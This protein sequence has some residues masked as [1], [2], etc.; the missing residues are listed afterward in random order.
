MRRG[1]R[2]LV[3]LFVA[4]VAALAVS[5][6]A[7]PMSGCGSRVVS[8][9]RDGRFDHHYPVA[10]YRNALTGLPEDLRLYSSAEG[11]IARE[12]QQ[13][14][15]VERVAAKSAARKSG[16]DDHVSPYLVALISVV[17]VVGASSLIALTR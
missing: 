9:W 14:V 13:R 3:A 4:F 17:L 6:T 5:G 2:H 7:E 1:G 12:L 10:C 16:S 11:D 8:D 15:R